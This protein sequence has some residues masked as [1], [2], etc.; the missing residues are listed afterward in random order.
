MHKS[1]I[2]LAMHGVPPKDFPRY[3]LAEFFGLYLH[4][5]HKGE[6]PPDRRQKHD[7]LQKKLQEWPRTPN[8]DPYFHSSQKLAKELSIITSCEVIVGFNEFCKPSIIEALETAIAKNPPKILVITPMMT[9]G[10]E[11]SEVDIP[12]AIEHIRK[13]HPAIKIK[14]IW[15]FDLSKV[16]KFLADQISTLTHEV[17][18]LE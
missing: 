5:E 18:P 7:K 16:A 8:N 10:G 3:E 13:R 17:F 12:A 9:P 6:L 15:P 1:I 14:Y 4:L 11:H 2:V